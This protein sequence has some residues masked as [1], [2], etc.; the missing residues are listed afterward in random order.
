MN[1]ITTILP[2][3][4]N[5]GIFLLQFDPVKSI[6]S[7]FSEVRSEL[8]KVTWPKRDEVIKL[9]II[10]LLV[11]VVVGAYVGGLDYLFTKAL[12]IIVSK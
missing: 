9:T 6:V 4:F 12:E 1:F 8:L 7:F 10:V 5:F 2:D 3:P 11:S